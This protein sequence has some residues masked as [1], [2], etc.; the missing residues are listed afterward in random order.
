MCMWNAERAKQYIKREGRT[1]EWLASK[2]GITVESLSHCLGGVRSPG[3][4]VLL[5]MAQALQCEPSDLDD[6][7]ESQQAG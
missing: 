7:F 2:C 6:N 4:P 5:L 1:R 3:K